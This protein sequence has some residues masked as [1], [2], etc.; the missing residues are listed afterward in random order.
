MYSRS[1]ASWSV[2]ACHEIRRTAGAAGLGGIG[3]ALGPG[4]HRSLAS[5]ASMLRARR[6]A[7]GQLQA[8]PRYPLNIAAQSPAGCR[9]RQRRL[10]AAN[11][12]AAQRASA[13]RDSG[14]PSGCLQASH[15]AH[16]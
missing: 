16:T 15:H 12:R 14:E 3:G 8:G 7:G 2:V 13:R 11:A 1:A 9:P 6:A 4:G 5:S 10:P